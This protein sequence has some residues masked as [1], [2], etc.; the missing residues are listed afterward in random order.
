MVKIIKTSKEPVSAMRFIGKKYG[1]ED[2]VNGLFGAKW[3]EWFKNGWFSQLEKLGILNGWGHYIGLMGHEDGK[4]K[5]WIGMFLSADT[6]VPEGFEYMDYP[7]CNLGVCRLK[8]NK[9]SIYCNEPMCC[10]RL[11]EEGYKILDQ[12]FICFER[13]PLSDDPDTANLEKDEMILDI[14]FFVS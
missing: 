8:G 7:A 3:D 2:R 11:E 5:Y 12:E 4:F 13:E 14:C 6:T 10:D 9:D 1:D